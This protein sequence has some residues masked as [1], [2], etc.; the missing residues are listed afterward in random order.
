MNTGPPEPTRD[1]APTMGDVMALPDAARALVLWLLRRGE[2]G[3]A[4][5]TAETGLD[6]GACRALLET[7]LGRGFLS[8]TG[9]DGGARYKARLAPRRAGAASGDIWGR[10]KG[11]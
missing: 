7:L 5:M 1:G 4:E 2:A 3:L 10:L 9:A 11:L 6:E 8:E